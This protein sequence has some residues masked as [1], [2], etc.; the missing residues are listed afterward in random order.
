MTAWQA[1]ELKHDRLRCAVAVQLDPAA[2]IELR[3]LGNDLEG[4]VSGVRHHP[5]PDVQVRWGE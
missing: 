4:A 1:P 3:R 5:R 2:A